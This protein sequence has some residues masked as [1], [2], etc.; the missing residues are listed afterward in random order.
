MLKKDF[1]NKDRIDWKV[2]LGG[3]S[4]FFSILFFFFSPLWSWI[5]MG[6]VITTVIIFIG[7]VVCLFCL[8]KAWSKPLLYFLIP[9]LLLSGIASVR[10]GVNTKKRYSKAMIADATESIIDD[11]LLSDEEFADWP[12]RSLDSDNLTCFLVPVKYDE[13]SVLDE[14]SDRDAYA[15]KALALSRDNT[16]DHDADSQ[17]IHMS[18]E[19]RFIGS[20]YKGQVIRSDY[21]V[22]YANRQYLKNNWG[23]EDYILLPESSL[24]VIKGIKL[25]GD[26]KFEDS[27][28]N[29]LRADS[30]GNPVGT[31]YL[32]RWYITGY[33]NPPVDS[34]KY[35]NLLEKAATNG[36]RMAQFE[37]AEAKLKSLHSSWVEKGKAEDFLRTA[38][39]L[40]AI[41][42]HTTLSVTRDAIRLLNSFY[43]ET[44]QNVKAYFRTRHYIGLISH[45]PIKYSEHLMN[46]LALPFPYYSEAR[47][48]IAE[49]EKINPPEPNCYYVHGLM[50]LNGK[51]EKKNYQKADVCFHFAADSL[52]YSKAFLG[53]AELCKETG[54]PGYDF[55]EML[56]NVDF[57]EMIVHEE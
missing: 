54:Q 30:L 49:G 42:T 56:Y 22:G 50:F 37:W 44:G 19:A 25:I 36:C 57:N 34:T 38:S 35:F 12:I 32:A 29:F 3:V 2:I 52:H 21:N 40:G 11:I 31:Y 26:S 8:D 46:C 7:I 43:H 18:S 47:S 15:K 10:T 28:Q 33:D 39:E 51:G 48:I 1:G 41:S 4:T 23:K 9:L 17:H 45:S 6:S 14:I 24:L 16:F 13:L 27:K 20:K 55:W 53:L 5:L